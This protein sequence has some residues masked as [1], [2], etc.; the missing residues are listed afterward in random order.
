ML[1]E[2]LSLIAPPRCCACRSA[3]RPAEALCGS[4][5]AAL[6]ALR[7]LIGPVPAP[8]DA[9]WAS[10]PYEGIAREVVSALKFGRL[11]AA[12]RVCAKRLANAPEALLAGTAVV[13]VPP[14]PRRLRSRGFDPAEE[15]AVCLAA[16]IGASFTPCLARADGDRQVG[17]PRAARISRPP[18][19]WC[20]RRPPPAALLVD[21]VITTGATAAACARALR[22][23]GAARVVVVAFARRP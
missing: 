16:E 9:A 11:I 5:S 20:R 15:I 14:T 7:P 22:G 6:E 18:S 1:P 13:P 2:V 4:C 19:V 3:C 21:D 23:G 10:A 12:A 8:A 17:R